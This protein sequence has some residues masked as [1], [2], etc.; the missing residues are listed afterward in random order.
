MKTLEVRFINKLLIILPPHHLTPLSFKCACAQ[1]GAVKI[2]KRI[3]WQVEDVRLPATYYKHKTPN[4]YFGVLCL[5]GVDPF[6]DPP[7][8]LFVLML[9]RETSPPCS[10]LS[11]YRVFAFIES[12]TD[13]IAS[14]CF[15]GIKQPFFPRRRPCF[16]C[17]LNQRAIQ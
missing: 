7:P 2:V 3:L 8:C 10:A 13:S 15:V 11:L 14:D 9:S 6:F 4:K 12:V 1:N 5:G 16:P 17:L